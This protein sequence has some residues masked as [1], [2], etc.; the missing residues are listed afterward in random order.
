MKITNTKLSII[1]EYEDK[2]KLFMDVEGF[3]EYQLMT[4]TVSLQVADA[5]GFEVF[6]STTY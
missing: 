6:A 4:K 3:P 2:F 1:S 5:Q